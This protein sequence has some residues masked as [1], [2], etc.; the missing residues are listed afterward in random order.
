MKSLY[1]KQTVLLLCIVF[2]VSTCQDEKEDPYTYSDTSEMSFDYE[3]S[4]RTFTI[5]A[6]GGWTAANAGTEWI[7]VSP[8]SG[9]GDGTVTVTVPRNSGRERKGKI[10]INANGEDINVDV[11]QADGFIIFDDPSLSK[12]LKAAVEMENVNITIPYQRA[13]GNESFTVSVAVSGPGAAGINGVQ[14]RQVALTA[15]TG[16]IV[17][18]VTGTPATKGEVTFTFTTTYSD[19]TISP[20]EIVVTDFT[21]GTPVF[22]SSASLAVTKKISDLTLNLPYADGQ[23]G[24]Q[25]VMS[26]EV[27]GVPGIKGVEGYVVE[28]A[29][30]D[31][32]ISIPITGVPYS[33]GEAVF[34]ISCVEA[35]F[36]EQLTLQVVDDGKRYYPGTILVTGAMT[37]PRG[38][39]CNTSM[40]VSWY[41]PNED[42]N[43]HGDGYEYVQLMAVENI[44][45]SITPYSVVICKNTA[46]QTPL[47]KGWAAGGARTYKFN[48]TE[49]TVT[50]G[51]FFYIGGAAKALNGYASNANPDYYSSYDG[52]IIDKYWAAYQISIP[53][54]ASQKG[55]TSQNGGI[56]SIKNAKWIRTKKY[57]SESGDGFGDPTASNNSNLLSNAQNAGATQT[58]GVDG[59]AVYEGTEVDENTIPLDLVFF[60]HSAN[61]ASNYTANGMGYTVALNDWYSPFD[62]ETGVAQ[63]FFG[64]GSN[65]GF[66][67]GGQP[68][69]TMALPCPDA[70]NPIPTPLVSQ[71]SQG[72]DCSAFIKFVGELGADNSWIKGREVKTVYLLDP[73]FHLEHYGLN[74]PAQLSDI[75]T[76]LVEAGEQG[77]VMIVR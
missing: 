60:G 62:I 47:A 58:V 65:T 42:A 57:I 55:G 43:E 21:L 30:P 25:F 54:W 15:S 75:E 46:A 72:R 3:A 20:I 33:V 7:S 35:D 38:N 53:E 69:L 52:S 6:N 66:L 13:V 28:L 5:I 76:N 68:E 27:T 56:V 73:K 4:S 39:D 31:G 64:Q 67:F 37:D 14:N 63:P 40:S 70:R 2:T 74:R 36:A 50:R 1:F 51:E 18:P 32:I 10:V 34:N 19:G 71:T 24:A 12:G 45:F 17:I 59:I 61:G 29:E 11:T 77:A 23:A 26:V 16:D 8:A 41:N 44:D 49:G 48:L 9:K 22:S